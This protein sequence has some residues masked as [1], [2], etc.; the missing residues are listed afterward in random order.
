M[1]R[2]KG[3][4]NEVALE[5]TRPQIWSSEKRTPSDVHGGQIFLISCLHDQLIY[6]TIDGKWNGLL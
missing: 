3:D 6:L 1:L 2:D 4:T 5:T